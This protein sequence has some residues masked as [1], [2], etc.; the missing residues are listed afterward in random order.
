MNLQTSVYENVIDAAVI[1]D[2]IPL[3]ELARNLEEAGEFDR[4]A[5]TLSP[6][7]NGYLNRPTRLRIRKRGAGGTV[8]EKRNL[9]G[10]LGSAKQVAGAQEVAKDFI[11][12]SA[13][14]FESLGMSEKV[15]RPE[16]IWRSV[17]GAKA[18][19]TR[20]E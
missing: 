15:E 16:L 18:D 7:W 2:V 8:A 4:A 1:D 10:W 6:F 19:W 13:S 14:V 17:I 9:E 11:S 3:C 12:E 20:L 5:E